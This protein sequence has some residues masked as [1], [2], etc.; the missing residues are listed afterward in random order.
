MQDSDISMCPQLKWWVREALAESLKLQNW[1][2][3]ILEKAFQDYVL[4]IPIASWGEGDGSPLQY[5]CL[6]N[7]MDGR[8]W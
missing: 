1:V 7:P 5:S 3:L 8:A 2:G 4:K 6:E